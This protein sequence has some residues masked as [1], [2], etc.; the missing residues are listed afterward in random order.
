METLTI[1]MIK[2]CFHLFL[3][4]ALGCDD[5]FKFTS[6]SSTTPNIDIFANDNSFLEEVFD[7]IIYLMT[8]HVLKTKYSFKLLRKSYL[9]HNSTYNGI[10]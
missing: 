3:S 5:L 2:N 8:K 9:R 7:T 6:F 1:V 4:S 10:F